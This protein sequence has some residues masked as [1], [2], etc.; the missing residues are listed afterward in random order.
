M[1]EWTTNNKNKNSNGNDGDIVTNNNNIVHSTNYN[2]N[3]F[4]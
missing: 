2:H 3:I 1:N 4:L